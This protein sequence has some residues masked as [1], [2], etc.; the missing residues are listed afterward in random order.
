MVPL[1]MLPMAIGCG[2]TFILKP[3]EKVPQTANRLVE[4]LYE[5]GVPAGVVSVIHGGAAQ[6]EHL[7]DHPLVRTVSI[8]GSSA[9]A[10]AVYARAAARGKRVQALGGAKNHMVVMPDADL[11]VTTEG[12][13]G[14]AF[15]ASGQRCMSGSV[16]VMVEPVADALLEKLKARAGGLRLTAGDAEGCEL[17]PLVNRA[18]RDRAAGY[19]EV[20]LQEGAALVLDGR[21]ATGQPGFFLG[22]TIFDH[23][24]PDMRIA[25]EE[26]FGPVLSIIRVQ[27]LDEA[28]ALVNRSTVG[29]GAVI[30]TR[31]GGAARTFASEVEAGMVGINVGVPAPM[32]FFPFSGW[33]GSFFGDLH[34]HGKDGVRFFTEQKVITSRFDRTAGDDPH[35]ARR[36]A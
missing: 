34:A 36:T 32:A 28:L 3:S 17:G 9:A 23:V 27:S 2:N 30:F 33:K 18:Q 11:H 31:D 21:P 8:V 29:N 22:A 1:W 5:A 14:S 25:R 6:V 20:G 12:I 35:R 7:I 16:A 4:L 26:I 13:I 15:G 19:I 24:T 10:G